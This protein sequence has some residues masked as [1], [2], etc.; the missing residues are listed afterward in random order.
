MAPS[1]AET[2]EG[3]VLTWLEPAAKKGGAT[4]L[5]LAQLQGDTWSEPRRITSGARLFANWADVPGLAEGPGGVLFAH[6]L[7]EIT[8]AAYAYGVRL[9]RSS[10]QGRTWESLGWLHDDTSA[11]EHGFVSYAPGSDGLQV[12]W[13]DGRKMPL[14]GAMALRVATLGAPAAAT[15]AA[16]PPSRQIDPR[17]CEC[18]QTDAASTTE[19]AVVVYRDR[20]S[21]ELRD[22]WIVRRDGQGW[23]EP[24]PVF[25]DG[26]R[27]EGCPVNGP[28][29]A[30]QGNHVVV[31]WYTAK[32]N[33]AKNEE[34]RIRV[35][36]SVDAGR[37][38]GPPQT[39]P[40]S[41]AAGSTLGRID[42]VLHSPET[43]GPEASNPETNNSEAPMLEAWISWLQ[44]TADGAVILAHTAELTSLGSLTLSSD[45]PIEIARTSASRRSGFPRL[46]I[47]RTSTPHRLVVAWV[48][49]KAEG[50]GQ[51]PAKTGESAASTTLRTAIRPLD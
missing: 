23:S 8:D 49:V 32:G 40:E 20:S 50:P 45:P 7:E 2:S 18:C 10:D 16:P 26:W 42:V 21:E 29:V 19:G 12:F 13:L 30:A 14:G 51:S 46:A 4:T 41:V 47:D 9:A 43:N 31:A 17:V 22:I 33:T 15:I 35:A 27:I 37:T 39:I 1:L 34:P 6:W 24:A 3:V 25:E 5:Y 11:A 38:F 28:A 36:Y 48:E 44:R